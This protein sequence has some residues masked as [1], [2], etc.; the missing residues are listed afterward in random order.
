M[1]IL[2]A[3]EFYSPALGGMAEVVRQLSERLAAF[4]H[5]VTVATT[6]LPERKDKTINGVKIAEFNLAG[7]YSVGIHGDAKSYERFLTDSNFDVVTNFAAQQ[8]STDIVLPI[9]DRIP[10]KKVFVPTGFSGLHSP[11]YA[12]YFEK[13]KLWMRGYDVNVFLSADYQDV[14]FARTNGIEKIRLIPNGAGEEFL[15]PPDPTFRKRLGIPED[16]FLLLLV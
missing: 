2:H 5:D 4:G 9:L 8:W 7:N 1:K 13:M 3:V 10:A 12:D 6:T 16:A 15:A 14:I 11:T